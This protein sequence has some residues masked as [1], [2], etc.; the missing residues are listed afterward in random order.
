MLIEKLIRI[1]KRD[2]NYKW[3]TT[4]SVRELAIILS[5]RGWQALRGL[6]LRLFLHESAG[7]VFCGKNVTVKHGASVSAGRN[8]I[9]DDNVYLNALSEQGIRLGHD[10]SIGRDAVMICTGVVAHKGVGIRIGN[11]TGINARAYFGGQGGIEIGNNVIIGP[12][13]RLFSENHNY[14]QAHILI[15]NQG[16]SR[17]GVRIGD[18]CWLGSNVTVLDGVTIGSGC[19]IA[20]GSVV[21]KSIPAD[22]IAAGV[23]AKVIRSRIP[24]EVA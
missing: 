12:D 11:G 24:C 10:V 16:V 6:R 7:L 1:L 15:K 22:S 23:P 18:N 9:L 17:R 5:D 2:P 3:E 20:A 14:E 19:V 21:T 4:Y 13:V 8:L